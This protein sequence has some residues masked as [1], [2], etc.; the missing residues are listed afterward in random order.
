MRRRATTSDER[1]LF[2]KS[3]DAP[4][5]P[6]SPKPGLS[7]GKKKISKPGLDG[8]TAQKLKKGDVDPDA[9]LDL[10]GLTQDAAHG[11]LL[12]FLRN[13]HRGRARLVLIVTGKGKREPDTFDMS[14]SGYGVLNRLVPRWLREPA[15]APFIAS[16]STAHRRH[17]GDGALYVYLR[18]SR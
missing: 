18:K 13:A 14:G 2:E 7:K 12:K 15:F 9:K 16:I 3:V 4:R 5:L 6:P 10:H 1:E 8:H 11:A 17:G